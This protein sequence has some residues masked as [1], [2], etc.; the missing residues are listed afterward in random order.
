MGKRQIVIYQLSK[1]TLI[2]FMDGRQAWSLAS[3]G[4][5][6]KS[7][8]FSAEN[9]RMASGV[10]AVQ[11]LAL[12]ADTT[13]RAAQFFY[14]TGFAQFFEKRLAIVTRPL[15]APGAS[16]IKTDYV[17]VCGN[18]KIKVSD[19]LEVFDCQEIIFDGSNKFYKLEGWKAACRE[20]GVKCHFTAE[21]GAWVEN[22]ASDD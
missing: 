21:E 8:R 22:L 17:L 2:D 13:L 15:P 1:N 5:P 7:V 20:A 4:V 12:N 10:S 19:I 14:R 9:Y 18:P 6:E 11:P 16:K 3:V